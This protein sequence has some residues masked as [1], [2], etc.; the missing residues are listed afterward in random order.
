MSFE[1]FLGIVGRP[2]SRP[3]VCRE[4]GHS[5]LKPSKSGLADG[6]EV[7]EVVLHIPPSVVK[8]CLSPYASF[9]L[10]L[11]MPTGSQ[12]QNSPY[13]RPVAPKLLHHHSGRRKLRIEESRFAGQSGV[14]GNIGVAMRSHEGLG[15]G[16]LL[17]WRVSGMFGAAACGFFSGGFGLHRHI[18]RGSRCLNPPIVAGA[19]GW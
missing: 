14:F 15:L 2:L 7:D 11:D 16:S 4:K 8:N 18:T 13:Q 1:A 19:L 3:L 17:G 12:A 6:L 5:S 9:S 10:A